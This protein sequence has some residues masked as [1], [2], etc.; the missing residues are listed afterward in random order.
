M[1]NFKSRLKNIHTF[2]FDIDGVL[3]DGK[4]IL[5]EG[6]EP[7][8]SLNIKDSFAIQSAIKKGYRIVIIS[9]GKS[10]VVAEGMKNLGVQDVFMKQHDKLACYKDFINEY[11]LNEAEILYM[12]DDLPDWEVMK[13]VGVACCP[14]DAATEIK[15]ISLYV[16]DKKGGE[17][18]V[19][20]VIEQ[21]MRVRKDW[22]VLNN[23]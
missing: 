23:K 14:N 6:H 19:R 1:E 16:S 17:G 3:T 7:L 18:C 2:I 5:M 10:E 15:E 21:V 12:G 9:S 13:R 4:V 20:D 22:G 8:R 11:S